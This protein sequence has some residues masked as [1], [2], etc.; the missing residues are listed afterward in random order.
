[1]RAFTVSIAVP[2][3]II[4]NAQSMELKTYLVGQIAKAATI[5]NVNEVIIISDDKAN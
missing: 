4:D 2:A 5:F 3:S 1:M